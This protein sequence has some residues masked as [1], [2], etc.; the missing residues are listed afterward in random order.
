MNN[1]NINI[2]NKKAYF[3]FEIL[4]N[5]IAG[6]VL[7]GTEI[8]SIRNGNISFNDSYCYFVNGELYLKN[9]HIAEYEN[10]TYN[11]HEPLRERKL[12]MTKRELKKLSEKVTEKGYTIVPL[13][14]YTTDKGL[15]KFDIGLARGK[16]DYDK[17][18]TIKKRDIDR[19]MKNEK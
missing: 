15:V 8:K 1:N 18:E 13:R 19:Y 2:K 16:K 9:F 6:V 12:L 4:D 10:G 17:R 7:Q 3:K 11:N 5:Y 14:I